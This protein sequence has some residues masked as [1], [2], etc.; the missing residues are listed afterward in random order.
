MKSPGPDHSTA[1]LP[2]FR[3]LFLIAGMVTIFL[4]FFTTETMT[5]AIPLLFLLRIYR[6]QE[7]Q[8]T[9]CNEALEHPY[10]NDGRLREN[11]ARRDVRDAH[12]AVSDEHCDV[13]G[14][15]T[16]RNA[17]RH[18]KSDAHPDHTKKGPWKM[19]LTNCALWASGYIGMWML[20]WALASFT[21]GR[22]AMPYVRNSIVEH[23]EAEPGM[24]L[25]SIRLKAIERCIT[26]L[27]PWEY[28]LP[29]AV[30]LL[31]FIAVFFFIPAMTGRLALRKNISRKWIGLY[32]FIGMIPYIRIFVIGNHSMVHAWFVYRAQAA[33][34]MALFFVLAEIL[35]FLPAKTT[36]S[37]VSE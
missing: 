11:N 36:A 15:H 6:R 22:S 21:L 17:A 1:Q 29:G 32:A 12:P 28:G 37:E 14:A 13:N 30:L 9:L 24:T 7:Q 26:L 18:A 10:G 5:L 23:L 20:K 4:D 31:L 19:V 8:E 16:A 25:L 27:F 3:S 2:D 33:S 35:E 34:V